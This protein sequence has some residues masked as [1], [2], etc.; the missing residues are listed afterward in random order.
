MPTDDFVGIALEGLSPIDQKGA[1]EESVQIADATLYYGKRP[2]FGRSNRVVVVQ[3]K[4]SIGK[5]AT[6]FRASDAKKTIEKFAATYLDFKCRYGVQQVNKKLNFELITNRKIATAFQEALRGI[7]N[8]KAVKADAKSQANQI[9]TASGLSGKE[10]SVFAKKIRLTGMAGS[11]RE[12]NQLLAGVIVNWSATHDV[13]ARARL[14][15]LRYLLRKKAGLEGE[16]QNIIARVDVLE[17]LGLSGSDE[18]LPCQSAFPAVGPIVPREQLASTLLRIPEATKPILVHAAG[19][20]G[21]TVFLQ[22]LAAALASEHEVLMFDCFGGGGYRAPEDSRHL[23]KRGLLHIV[24]SLACKGYCDPL[25][26]SNDDA[27]ALMRAF[28]NRL[29]QVVEMLKQV[30]PGAKLLLFIDAIDNAADQAKDKKQP[31]FPMLILESIHHNGLIEGVKLVVSCRTH[32]CDLSRGE[33]PCEEIQL[34]PFTKDEAAKYLQTRITP[35]TNSQ[36]EVAF[37]RSG[38]NPRILEHLALSDRGLLEPSELEKPIALDTLLAERIERALK[39]AIRRGYSK[40]NIDAFLAGL[41]VLPPPVPVAE[42]ANAHG[43]DVAAVESFAADLAPLLEQTKH[44]LAFRDEPTE[45]F[46]KDNYAAKKATLRKLANNLFDNQKTSVYAASALPGLLT[47]LDDSATLFRLAFDD[48]FPKAIST[49]IGQ[50]HIRHS[51]LT[52]AVSLAAKKG[53]KGRLVQLLV[54]LSSLAAVNQRGTA[55]IVNNPDLVVASSDVDATRR[56]FEIRTAWA[57]TRHSRLAIAHA[58]GGDI[59]EATRHA[60]SAEEWMQHHSK[61]DD[62]T[63][64][65]RRGPELLDKAA[66]A[67]CIAAQSRAKDAARYMGGYYDWAAFEIA[68]HLFGF[69]AQAVSMQTIPQSCLDNVLQAMSAEIGGIAA[70]IGFL[71]LDSRVTGRLIEKLASTCKKCKD[72]KIRNDYQGELDH[73]LQHSLLKAAAIAVAMKRHT[74]A[75]RIASAVPESRQDVYAFPDHFSN[76]SVSLQLIRAATI[77]VSERQDVSVGKVLPSGLALLSSRIATGL[78][79]EAFRN[80]L[81]VELKNEVEVQQKLP[82]EK[83]IHA[84]DRQD[85]LV[86][87]IDKRLE[88]VLEITR[89]LAEVLGCRSGKADEKFLKIVDLWFANRTKQVGYE[90]RQ[91]NSFFDVVGRQIV[92]FIMWARKDLTLDSVKAALEKLFQ[93]SAPTNLIVGLVAALARRPAFQQLAGETAIKVKTLIEQE[94]EVD[95]RAS[96]LADLARAILSAS[97]EEAATYF[98]AGL[99]QMDA[100]GSGDYEFTNELLYFASTIKGKEISISDFHTLANICELNMGDSDRTSWGI[101]GRAFARTGGSRAF[102]KLARWNDQGKATFEYSLLPFLKALV[103]DGKMEPTLATTLLHLGKPVELND[104]GTP[105]FASALKQKAPTNLKELVT[106]LIDSFER[107]H[108]EAHFARTRQ[109]LSEVAKEIFGDDFPE[110]KYLAERAA[111]YGRVIEEDNERINYRSNFPTPKV[112]GKKKAEAKKRRVFLAISKKANPLDE[113]SLSV[114]VEGID[115]LE[116]SYDLKREFFDRVRTRVPFGRQSEYLKLVAGIPNLDI[117]PK[118]QELTRCKEL[119]GSSSAALQPSFRETAARLVRLHASDLIT[120][121][122]FSSYIVNQIADLSGV[123]IAEIAITTAELFAETRPTLPAQIWL[124]LASTINKEAAAGEAQA[125]L[126]RLLNSGAAKLASKAVDGPYKANLYVGE[127]EETTCAHLIWQSLGSEWAGWRWRAAHTIR[128]AAQLGSWGVIE[129]LL[130]CWNSVTA[131]PYQAGELKFYHFHAKLWTLIALARVAIDHPKE[132]LKHK[133]FLKRVALGK[134]GAHVSQRHF[135]ALALLQ[136]ANAQPSEFSKADITNLKNVNASSF[137]PVKASQPWGNSYYQPRPAT[138]PEPPDDFH[139]DYDFD[140]NEVTTIGNV[141]DK[142]HWE[143]GDAITRWVRGFDTTVKGMYDHG[144]REEG[145][146]DRYMSMNSEHHGYGQYL[147]WHGLYEAAGDFL[148]KFPTVISEYDDDRWTSWFSNQTLSCSDGLWLSDGLDRPPIEIQ[149]NLMETDSSGVNL[150][151]NKQKILSLLGIKNT[152]TDGLVVCG[153]WQSADNIEVKISSAL[154]PI[155]ESETVAKRLAKMEPFHVSLPFFD[156]ESPDPRTGRDEQKGVEWT[157]Q[158]SITSKLDQTDPWGSHSALAAR[159]KS[160]SFSIC[161][162]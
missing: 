3:V 145:R 77:A 61:L 108:P 1:S 4:Y 80:A 114:A 48:R 43:I 44:G 35:V 17:C 79:D 137:P 146:C 123:P 21:K 117:Y 107:N 131:G 57:G 122:H 75:E 45:T 121:D 16:G 119:W 22:S 42:Y 138:L 53:E 59:G 134:D 65:Q 136:C 135:A 102:A 159:L 41:A 62:N 89:L 96:M 140:K 124:G 52:A 32:R 33:I 150:T 14:G 115:K 97:S 116:R 148:K 154:L 63:R 8:G 46:V 143:V 101:L 106:T 12:N 13:L 127:G 157:L 76:R 90:A 162:K 30:R 56:L 133:P 66:I 104:C 125:A 10:L 25:L 98:R 120:H 9:K 31:S 74:H 29:T 23:P 141:F 40:P 15:D 69:L 71:E 49:K 68:Q 156:E 91:F 6:P 158:P 99:E 82:I 126:H 20:V 110:V 152:N 34:L 5:G 81:K 2:H 58:L 70:A 88:S 113:Q 132:V 36:I 84:F 105:E 111:H 47:K 109:Q 11:L 86:Y 83:R 151:S 142:T 64:R 28:R 94:D 73:H 72:L 118:L 160:H 19:G 103:E 60:K 100:I 78:T 112:K 155:E 128:I 92:S 87:F 161:L 144:G 37:A 24:N 18:L 139:L 55:Y 27:E 130:G 54:E 39:E 67:L 38:G 50:Q 26:P 95:G 85:E 153:N 93:A 147:G 149:S 129:K 51:R 7:A